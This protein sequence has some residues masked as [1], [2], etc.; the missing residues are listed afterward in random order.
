MRITAGSAKGHPIKVPKRVDLR[1]TKDM[2]RQ[3]IFS[4][5]GSEIKGKKIL[6]LY[7]GTGA[8]GLEALSRGGLSC[9]FVDINLDCCRA[10]RENL[11]HLHLQGRGRVICKSASLY[12]EEA[13]P[14]HYDMIFLDPPYSL[15]DLPKLILKL[16][17]ILKTKGLIIAEHKKSIKF[18]EN[19]SELEV[20]DRRQYGDTSLT[21]FKKA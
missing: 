9:D 16:N 15:L 12:I 21:F 14:E 4:I 19:L 8:L 10:I 13:L 3:V 11:Q 2:V 17:K 18:T 5:I 20:I 1:P 7:A 6:D